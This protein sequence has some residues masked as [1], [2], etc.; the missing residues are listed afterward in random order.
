M[1]A[2]CCSVAPELLRE[3]AYRQAGF[4]GAHQFINFVWLQ[5]LLLLA[6]S[7]G[8]LVPIIYTSN[9]RV[10][11]GSRGNGVLEKCWPFTRVGRWKVH[12]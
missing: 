2:N 4:V 5:P 7:T 12:Q 10:R 3:L 11:A 1:S 8:A 6:P 9:W